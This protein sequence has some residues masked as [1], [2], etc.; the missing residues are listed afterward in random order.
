MKKPLPEKYDISPVKLFDEQITFPLRW[1]Y[2][3]NHLSPYLQ[4]L[5]NVLDLGA[6]CGRLTKKLSEKL[7]HIDFVGIDTHV[8]SKTYIPISE[9]DGK[10]IPYPDNSFDC[11]MMVDVVHHIEHPEIILEEVKRVSKKYILIKDHYWNNKFDL[12]L[13]K[14]SDY[15]G[16]K[17]Y[18]VN[19]PYN[20]FR[21]SQWN[22]LIK[23][24]NLKTIRT[25]KFRCNIIDPC[26]H[27]IFLLEK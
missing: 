2:L 4:N 9:Y 14:F 24:L 20:F 6:S 7:P 25:E 8:Q 21:V 27:I 26:R 16:N 3:T 5:T 13:L 15:I 1:K 19:L 18:G 23:S 11:V 17:P 22:E 12:S 10:K